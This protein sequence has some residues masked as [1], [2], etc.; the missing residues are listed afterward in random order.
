MSKKDDE[1]KIRW[2]LLPLDVIQEVIKVLMHGEK[3]YSAFGWKDLPNWRERYYDA[4][5]RHIT[6]WAQG[7][8][9]DKDSGYPHLACAICNL[10]FLRYLESREKEAPLPHS[11]VL[12]I[13]CSCCGVLTTYTTGES[14]LFVNGNPMCPLCL[15]R[16]SD[17]QH[18]GDRY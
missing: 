13:V 10:I 16:K 9:I 8:E 12:E 17:N 2:S 1:G 5:M 3:K 15:N 11:S 18:D 6:K 4:A 7:T 14:P